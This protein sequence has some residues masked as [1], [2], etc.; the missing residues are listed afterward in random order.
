[1]WASVIA[2]GFSVNSDLRL[3]NIDIEVGQCHVFVM[4]VI[5]ICLQHLLCAL[6]YS[7]SCACINSCSHKRKVLT[8]IAYF[9]NEESKA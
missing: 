4:M 5:Q 1:M 8:I 6:H 3:I 9:T 7:K 2:R